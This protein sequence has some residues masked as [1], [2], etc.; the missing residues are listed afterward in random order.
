MEKI[1]EKRNII[2]R[3]NKVEMAKNNEQCAL[4]VAY[5]NT[6]KV[7]GLMLDLPETKRTGQTPAQV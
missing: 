2:C 7:L 6:H 3:E 4:Q 5:T 1:R